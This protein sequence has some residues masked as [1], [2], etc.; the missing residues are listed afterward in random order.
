MQRQRH[1][2]DNAREWLGENLAFV[3]IATVIT[4]LFLSS[5]LMQS[6]EVSDPGKIT[7]TSDTGRRD[8]VKIKFMSPGDAVMEMSY[9]QLLRVFER[10]NPDI[11]VEFIKPADQ[12]YGVFVTTQ[13]AGGNAADVMFFEDEIFP[14][15][16]EEGVF[17]PLDDF[18]R[19]ENYD[20]TDFFP[21][22]LRE[23]SH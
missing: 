9:R 1:R 2:L 21:I 15:F 10:E 14:N 5:F 16:A 20:L 17:L 13:M 18:V 8:R 19:R 23:F 12:R 11:E 6:A 7:R 3:V 4:V 22:G